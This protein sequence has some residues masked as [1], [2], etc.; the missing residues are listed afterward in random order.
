[1]EDTLPSLVGSSVSVPAEGDLLPMGPDGN[2]TN[3]ETVHDRV[4][5]F[6]GFKVTARLHGDLVA[7]GITSDSYSG[8]LCLTLVWANGTKTVSTI[9]VRSGKTM[10]SSGVT[11]PDGLLPQSILLRQCDANDK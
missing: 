8:N 4:W 3:A 2:R 9:K 10:P 6:E 11:T 5:R 1:M 7:L